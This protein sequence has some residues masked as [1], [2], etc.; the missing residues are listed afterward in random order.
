M[1]VVD[2][3]LTIDAVVDPCEARASVLAG[4]YDTSVPLAESGPPTVPAG[5]RLR[6]AALGLPI[7][8]QMPSTGGASIERHFATDLSMVGP[9]RPDGSWATESV[10]VS[11]YVPTT[12]VADPCSAWLA[13]L[14][15]LDRTIDGIV[16]YI[17]GLADFGIRR[18]EATETTFAGLPGVTFDVTV[19]DAACG[20]GV[21]FRSGP[22][23]AFGTIGSPAR[24]TV[25]QHPDGPVIVV[26]V[27]RLGAADPVSAAWADE[28]A[29]SISFAPLE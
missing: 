29:A 19:A 15:P 7:A 4:R 24:L 2:G 25:L 18:T 16:A 1:S 8:L 14:V 28:L 23:A 22:G 20:G 26:V 17:D 5:V 13:K 12:G 9:I 21:L 6:S 27:G 11:V 3:R 10:I